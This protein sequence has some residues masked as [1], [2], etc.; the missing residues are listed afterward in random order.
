MTE[1]PETPETGPN[2]AQS[3]YWN[4]AAGDQWTRDQVA[5]D[6]FLSLLTERLFH[7]A[8]IQPGERILDIGCGTGATALGAA[9]AAGAGG[10]V[11]GIDLSHAML[12]LA[13]ARAEA[14]N[15][16]ENLTLEIADAQSHAFAQGAYDLLQSRFGVMFFADPTAAF[17]NLLGALRPSGRI[18]F[19]C[20]GPLAE[21]HWFR[22]SGAAAVKFLG[23]P[24]PTDPRAPGPLAFADPDY[25]T[26]ILS[27]A[28]FVDVRIS[29]ETRD[30]LG[31]ASA[32]EA[33][34]NAL[35][36]GPA[37]R[38]IAAHD[39]PPETIAAIR[40]E[41]EKG[42]SKYHGSGGVRVPAGLHFVHARRA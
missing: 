10:A 24:D 42:L 30:L 37:A 6:R 4:A 2:S 5:Q 13:R 40:A 15:G 39:P 12:G 19:V 27:E 14:M 38:L 29:S 36:R 31:A 35:Q 41:I 26:G 33:A 25:V 28:G 23:E 22:I 9:K 34:G 17:A 21:H 1:Q 20:W 3:K 18:C 11:L 32:A 7:H 16:M 8:A